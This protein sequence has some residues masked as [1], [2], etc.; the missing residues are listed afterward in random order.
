MEPTHFRAHGIL[1]GLNHFLPHPAASGLP[2]L[3]KPNLM[4]GFRMGLPS[5]QAVAAMM[6]EDV[7]LDKVLRV[8]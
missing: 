8:G 4:R 2:S 5:G 6:E 7:I 3:D 1:R